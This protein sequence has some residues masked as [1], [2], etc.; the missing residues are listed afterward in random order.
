M[1]SSKILSKC[2]IDRNKSQLGAE[3]LVTP[4]TRLQPGFKLCAWQNG[5]RYDMSSTTRCST[6]FTRTG[7]NIYFWQLWF[8]ATDQPQT[9]EVQVT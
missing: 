7:M 2:L 5:D 8:P 3:L 6:N 4:P 1:A 9:H